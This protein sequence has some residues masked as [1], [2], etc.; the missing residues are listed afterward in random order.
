MV[1]RLSGVFMMIPDSG[2]FH[3]SWHY[4]PS[5]W[6]D[7]IYSRQPNIWRYD[8]GAFIPLFTMHDGFSPVMAIGLDFA[9]SQ[10]STTGL[11]I[12]GCIALLSVTSWL[13]IATKLHQLSSARSANAEFLRVFRHSS[14]PL[15]VFQ[16]GEFFDFSPLFHIYYAAARELAFH[17]VGVDQP[18]KTFSQRLQG[19]GKITSSQCNAIRRAMERSMNEACVKVEA[20]LSLVAIAVSA[21]PILGLLGTVWGIMESFSEV[22]ASKGAIPLQGIVPGVS[23][24][25]LTTLFGLLVAVPSLVGYNFLVSRIRAMTLRLENFVGEI[26]TVL[27]RHYVD[28]RAVADELPSLSSMGPPAMAGYASAAAAPFPKGVSSP[29]TL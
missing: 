19:A 25:M 8:G 16:S 24:A 9:L 6:Q 14:H 3:E 23:A 20:R 13:I 2:F 28:H 4:E 29:A 7:E 15:S 10:T 1:R 22:A 11:V 21:A 12:C 17:L 27:D 26:G 18:D 5:R